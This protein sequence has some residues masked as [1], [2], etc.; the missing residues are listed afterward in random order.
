MQQFG[1][2]FLLLLLFVV[3]L[4]TLAQRL[5]TPYPIV[6]VVGGLLLS[7]VPGLPRVS[8]DPQMIFVVM[9]PPLLFSAAF[10]TSWRDFRHNLISILPLAFGLV[11]FTT[12]GVGITAWWLLPG[13]DWRLG[14]VLGAVISPTDALAATSIAK[15]LGL[16]KR[17]SDILEG[18]SLVND[19]SGLLALEFAVAIIVSGHT[20]SAAKAIWQLIYLVIGG[21]VA[22]LVLGKVV[23]I[24]EHWVDNPPIEIT[25]SII[26]PY[27]AYLG[28][29]R[30]DASGVLSVVACGLYLGWRSS[31]YFSS[32]A[33]L[34][35]WATW[36]TL[37]FILNGLAF[38]LIGLQLRY[39]IAGI[40]QVSLETLVF[41]AAV[42]VLLVMVLR[43]AWVYSEAY[44]SSVVTRK[45][46]NQATPLASS[47]GIFIVGWTGMRGVV[48]LA[49]AISLPQALESGKPFPA[50]N[51]IVFLTF[52]V[53]FVTLVLQGLTLPALIRR[54]G[55]SRKTGK[56]PEE[57]KARQTIIRS[58]LEQLDTM[59]AHGK[60]EFSSV[61]EHVAEHYRAR[62]AAAG[63]EDDEM[64]EFK[65]E[66]Y[67]LYRQ[68]TQK[69]REVERS[70]AVK[71]RNENEINDA[72]LRRLE[73][74][75]DLLDVRYQ[76]LKQ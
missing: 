61:Y 45:L 42:V 39:V 15:R 6:L 25:A 27:L 44:L 63:G 36:N 23:Y 33:R 62:L 71:L 28:A 5:K 75:L 20:P 26:A 22:G 7:L 41:S 64:E 12:L 74:E 16:P 53:I 8:L 4:G 67:E 19:G 65:P 10:N 13:F 3:G 1:S 49:A 54:L 50:R 70:T 37:T 43:L 66:V 59:Q 30:I 57:D 35:A 48:S 2:I 34:Q 52:C 51:M 73:R 32:T 29:E 60:P 24:F 40:R 46:S 72:V 9:L 69:L 38:L 11:A 68:I 47:R 14:L 18:E 58:A 76:G 21:I 31:V 55:L 56:N 17:I